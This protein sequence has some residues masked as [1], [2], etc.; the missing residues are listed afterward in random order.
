RA[1]GRG[2]RGVPR[3]HTDAAFGNRGNLF[4]KVQREVAPRPLV[5]RLVLNPHEFRAVVL[6]D[7]RSDLLGGKR[8]ELLD[9]YEGEILPVLL[10][11]LGEQVVVDPPGAQDDAGDLRRIGSSVAD[12]R[13]EGSAG[14]VFDLRGRC[15]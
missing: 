6:G 15:T 4:G 8:V 1:G 3:D 13:L 5:L 11:A 12:H 10:T 7:L 2:G 9:P 14:E